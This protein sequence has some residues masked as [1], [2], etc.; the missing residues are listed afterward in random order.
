VSK[1]GGNPKRRP[2]CAGGT[3]WGRIN[4]IAVGVSFGRLERW[5][6]QEKTDCH[7]EDIY[8]FLYSTVLFR[9]TLEKHLV[10]AGIAGHNFSND[11]SQCQFEQPS[12]TETRTVPRY[13]SI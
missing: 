3:T 2:I 12:V 11:Q 1:A 8:T 9:K 10:K 4:V 13:Q 7:S 5:Q 6:T